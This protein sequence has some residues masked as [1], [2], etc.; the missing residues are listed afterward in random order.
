MMMTPEV[1]DVFNAMLARLKHIESCIKSGDDDNVID[2]SD[3]PKYEELPQLNRE[4]VS[5]THIKNTYEIEYS[6]CSHHARI[7][8]VRGKFANGTPTAAILICPPEVNEI[9]F[10]RDYYSE[11]DLLWNIPTGASE[12]QIQPTGSLE[13][14]PDW[15]CPFAD[16]LVR[17]LDAGDYQEMMTFNAFDDTSHGAVT[18]KAC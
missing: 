13:K 17:N 12:L 18:A 16:D 15:G 8:V 1:R 11:G 9:T 7:Y 2:W 14:N 6:D 5:A 10:H 4:I 3:K